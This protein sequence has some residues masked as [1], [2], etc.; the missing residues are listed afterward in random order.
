MTRVSARA[1]VSSVCCVLI[2]VV[3]VA[4]AVPKLLDPGSFAADIHNYRM[5]PESLTGHAALYVPALELMVALGLLWPRYQ[6]GA[7]CLATLMLAGFAVAMAQARLRGIDL[8]CGCFGAAFESKV[9]WWT[10]ARSGTLAVLSAIPALTLR[11]AHTDLLGGE[12]VQG[13][14]RVN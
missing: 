14:S 1:I 12:A 10:V 13:P 6:R 2:A 4:A 3:F 8:S 9:S 11:G 5:L 7:A